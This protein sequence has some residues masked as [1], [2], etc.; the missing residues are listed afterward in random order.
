[1]INKET[2]GIVQNVTAW[3]VN[4]LEHMNISRMTA[5][6]YRTRHSILAN[7]LQQL[8]LNGGQMDCFFVIT[9][10]EG[11]SQMELA[12]HLFAGK[13]VTAKWV[14]A[15]IEKGYVQRLADEQDKRVCHLYL[16]EK[17]RDAAPLVQQIFREQLQLHLCNLTDDEAGQLNLLLEKV[18]AGLLDEKNRLEQ[19][20][21][22]KDRQE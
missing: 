16:T 18:L 19:E 9:L 14:K 20:Q 7:R 10:R 3:E 22:R 15:L 8:E 17:G 11:L 12:Q 1:M 2:I 4:G 21:E 5:A 6:I 13:S